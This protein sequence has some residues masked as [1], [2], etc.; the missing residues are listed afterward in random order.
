MDSADSRYEAQNDRMPDG[1]PSGD[2]QD[3]DYVSRTGQKK[4]PVPVLADVADVGEGVDSETAD[5]DEQLGVF[6]LLIFLCFVYR[7]WIWIF[8]NWMGWARIRK[9]KAKVLMDIMVSSSR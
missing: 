6:V 9:R 4:G 7:I 1:A 3:N 8:R 5:S 2:V